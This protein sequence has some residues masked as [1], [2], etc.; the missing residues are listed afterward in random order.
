MAVPDAH[1]IVPYLDVAT[2]CW[3]AYKDRKGG[4]PRRGPWLWL[5]CKGNKWKVVEEIERGPLHAIVVQGSRENK[6]K[7]SGKIIL[8]FSGTD[9]WADW[10]DNIDQGLKGISDQYFQALMISKAYVCEMVVGHSLG[11]GLAS[12]VAIHRGIKAATV[13]PAPLRVSAINNAEIINKR[14]YLVK[15][16]VVLGEVLDILDKRSSKMTRVGEIIPV[17]PKA[18]DAM[19]SITLHMLDNLAGF[20]P[21]T[22]IKI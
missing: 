19:D 8:A 15:N 3:L 10:R 17:K 18:G 12:F 14:S 1:G 16:Y 2:L 11:G 7:V 13:N 20:A 21:P 6:N 4:E 9:E 22:K 5:S